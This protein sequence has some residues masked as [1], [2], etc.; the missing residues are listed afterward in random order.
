MKF[1]FVQMSTYFLSRIFFF[2]Y[3]K[4][5]LISISLLKFISESF[6]R[7]CKKKASTDTFFLF[8]FVLCFRFYSSYFGL[9]SGKFLIEYF[10]YVFGVRNTKKKKSEL[11]YGTFIVETGKCQNVF[12]KRI[13][14]KCSNKFQVNTFHKS[15]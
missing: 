5:K 10:N 15:C 12:F 1:L 2:F 9:N 6:K 4:S 8:L 13:L 7:N 11:N 14:S 3:L